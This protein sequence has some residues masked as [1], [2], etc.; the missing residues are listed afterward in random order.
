M[1][2]NGSIPQASSEVWLETAKVE[3]ALMLRR[4]PVSRPC[5]SLGFEARR[6]VISQNTI[7]RVENEY[8]V[9]TQGEVRALERADVPNSSFNRLWVRAST[10]WRA[11]SQELGQKDGF[12]SKQRKDQ[13]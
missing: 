9:R 8:G 3:D 1:L 7:L 11:G 5:P 10:C 4:E 13:I 12:P 2:A 6:P